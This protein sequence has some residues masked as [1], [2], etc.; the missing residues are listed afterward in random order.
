MQIA[1]LGPLEVTSDSGAPV[2]VSGP[3]LRRLLILLALDADRVVDTGRLIDGLWEDE[4]PTGAANALQ[5]LVSRLRRSVPDAPIESHPT[6]YR[7]AV[8]PAAVDVSRFERL[9]GAGRALLRSDPPGAATVLADA[10]DLWRG[11]AL[12]DVAHAD[13]ARGPAAR[14][15]ELRLTATEQR[16]DARL[17]SGEAAALVPELHAL[18]RAHPVRERFAGQLIRALRATDRPAEALAAYARLR[19]TLAETLGT[20]PAPELAA[21]HLE[22]LRDADPTRPTSHPGPASTPAALPPVTGR[23]PSAEPLR[24]TNLPIP[25]TSFVG[26]EEELGRVT[27]LLAG[28]RLVTLT[29]PGG[30]GKTRLA[31]ESART[32]LARE[33]DGLWLVELAPVTDGAEVP[34]AILQLL[35]LREQGMLAAARNRIL[36]P[37]VADPVGRLVS[38]IASRRVVLLLDNCEHVLDAAAALAERLLGA[39]PQLRVLATSREPLGITGETLCPVESLPLPPPTADPATAMAYPAVRL[40]A[41]RAGAARPDFAVDTDTVAPVIQICRSLDG[42]PLAIELAAARLRTMTPAQ[43]A[44]RLDDRFR[45]L[46]GGSR[47]ALPR[48]QT[49]RAVFDWSWEPLDDA[50]RALWRRLAV[51]TGGATLDAIERICATDDTDTPAENDGAGDV[52]GRADVLDRLSALVDKSLVVVSGNGEPR[53][54]MLETTREYGLRRLA[55]AG[56]TDRVRQAHAA[57]FLALARTADAEL[58]RSDQLH[59]L[60]WLSTEHDNLH[61]ALRWAIATGNAPLAVGLVAAL[62]WYWWMRGM[63]VEG[64]ELALPALALPGVDRL[65]RDQVAVAEMM[66]AMNLLATSGELSLGSEWLTRAGRTAKG[67]EQAHPLLR[68][69]EPMSVIF[70]CYLGE[71]ALNLLVARFDDPDPWVRAVCRTFHAH[72][73]LNMGCPDERPEADMLLALDGFRT[74]GERWGTAYA[75]SAL[76]DLAGRRGEHER[77]AEFHG[78]AVDLMRVVGAA[79]DLPMM[80]IRLA[81]ELWQVGERE[82]AMALLLDADREAERIGSD[83]CRAAVAH[84]HAEILRTTGDPRGAQRRLDQAD[85]LATKHTTAPQWR[86]ML[87]SSQGAVAAALGD[88]PASRQ[89]HDRALSMALKFYDAPVISVVLVGCADLALRIGRPEQTALLLG[90][91][92][93]IRGGP[94]WSILDGPRIETAAREAL[95]EANFTE[96]FARGRTSA[97]PTGLPEL[98][99]A[100]LD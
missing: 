100:A 50:E 28:S 17:A 11:P 24:P 78:E 59:W 79:E 37:E 68:L 94:D 89:H 4:P 77:A 67:H 33:L 97:S 88:L 35:G 14:L 63:R 23:T 6:G 32:L 9:V 60:G 29:G 65:P 75:I 69:I 64:V 25:L 55:E 46:T 19:S 72:A 13:F 52:L 41:D 90:A 73:E 71:P 2:P 7:L 12:A 58:R 5:A 61:A 26:R 56:E 95:G 49:L 42:M 1:M 39:C 70:E 86:A 38:A 96:T 36:V 44:A 76:A 98:V 91:A 84:E 85:A 20:E 74:I 80:Q 47:T 40:L 54:R 22:L 8:E 27:E 45:L 48:H 10:L 62:G 30:A 57:D 43:V 93:A 82:R 16:I 3:R 92:H 51:F 83:E 15:D 21:L 31:T 66:T 18:A 34:Q 53:Y 99:K 81:H 87:A